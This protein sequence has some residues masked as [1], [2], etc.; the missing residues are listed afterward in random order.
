MEH[1]AFNYFE[2]LMWV[3]GHSWPTSL[4][5]H[6][7]QANQKKI[8]GAT[9]PWNF[10]GDSLELQQFK[11]VQFNSCYNKFLFLSPNIVEWYERTKRQKAKQSHPRDSSAALKDRIHVFR[12]WISDIFDYR[13]THDCEQTYFHEEV[14]RNLVCFLENMQVGCGVTRWLGLRFLKVWFK[15]QNLPHHLSGYCL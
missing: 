15:F 1:E 5:K 2:W 12:L 11:A 4:E 6:S 10:A 3:E 8:D 14:I 7:H 9:L 13:S